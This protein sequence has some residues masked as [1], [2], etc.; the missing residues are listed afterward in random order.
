[1]TLINRDEQ[2][3]EFYSDCS[4]L[5]DMQLEIMSDEYFKRKSRQERDAENYANCLRLGTPFTPLI[6]PTRESMLSFFFIV[7]TLRE[8]VTDFMSRLGLIKE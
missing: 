5:T 7:Q 4:H 3:K 2:R 6:A 1:M 8:P